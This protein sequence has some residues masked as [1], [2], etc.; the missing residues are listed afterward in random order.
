MPRSKKTTVPDHHKELENLRK[1]ITSLKHNVIALSRSLKDEVAFEATHGVEVVR[2]KSLES[3]D[4]VGE[5]VRQRPGQ[6][7]FMAFTAGLLTS[8]LMK[9]V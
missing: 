6:T 3:L 4:N 9:R 5:V 7:L 1:D 8:A 2:E